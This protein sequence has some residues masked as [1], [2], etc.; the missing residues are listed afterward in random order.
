[1]FKSLPTPVVTL[2]DILNS[3]AC[4][5][6][7]IIN[8]VY[9]KPLSAEHNTAAQTLDIM[10]EARLDDDF[11]TFLSLYKQELYTSATSQLSSWEY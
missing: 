9:G 6:D 10:Q 5:A 2:T 4:D 1:M 3:P 8:Q 11:S 7:A